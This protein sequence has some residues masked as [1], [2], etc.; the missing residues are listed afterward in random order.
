VLGQFGKIIGQ[1]QEDSNKL[2]SAD[3]SDLF[4]KGLADKMT[5]GS[6]LM[7]SLQI[8]LEEFKQMS[9]SYQRERERDQKYDALS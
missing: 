2:G 8:E 1:L 4:R 9:I 7:K 6:S 3:D 5:R